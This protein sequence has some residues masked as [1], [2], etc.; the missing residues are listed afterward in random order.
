MI[1]PLSDEARD[2]I[3]KA[4][5]RATILDRALRRAS[6]LSEIDAT[7]D[8]YGEHFALYGYDRSWPVAL[9]RHRQHWPDG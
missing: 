9:T 6:F 7:H 5:Q 4:S 8:R 1:C 2:N 3:R